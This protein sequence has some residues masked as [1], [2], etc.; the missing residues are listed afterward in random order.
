MLRA[1]SGF[2]SEALCR[3]VSLASIC[4]VQPRVRPVTRSR[5]KS[6]LPT[7]SSTKPSSRLPPTGSKVFTMSSQSRWVRKSMR[8]TTTG[9]CS[10]VRHSSALAIR[11]PVPPGGVAATGC[12]VCEQAP[13]SR[14]ALR[15]RDRAGPFVNRRMKPPVKARQKQ[16]GGAAGS[17][18]MNWSVP[19]H[20][21]TRPPAAV[22]RAVQPC[23]MPA[24]PRPGPD[25]RWAYTRAQ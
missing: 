9:F 13:S 7:S 14:D 15:I 12:G 16:P 6:A 3:C 25:P 8:D 22:G 10:K 21:N 5:S 20:C 23:G 24:L 4:T 18:Q 1:P 2:F 17:V 19:V 11:V